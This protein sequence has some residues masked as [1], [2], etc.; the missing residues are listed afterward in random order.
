MIHQ[1]FVSLDSLG[2]DRRDL[3]VSAL[4]PF[5]ALSAGQWPNAIVRMRACLTLEDLRRW[6]YVGFSCLWC[7]IHL[8]PLSHVDRLGSS[9]HFRRFQDLISREMI[10][11]DVAMLLPRH[12]DHEFPDHNF[13]LLF[14]NDVM[15]DA[16]SVLREKNRL[17]K[18]GA[19][20][21][22]RCQVLM[23]EAIAARRNAHLL[24]Y[25]MARA[26]LAE[27]PPTYVL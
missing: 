17:I 2:V 19:P 22:K 11:T 7:R 13:Y 21:K 3:Q 24:G 14:W 12:D 16:E 8:W 6:K 10:F 20:W 1:G 18:A 26:V 27:K 15:D 25:I 5:K 23:K 4:K 9:F